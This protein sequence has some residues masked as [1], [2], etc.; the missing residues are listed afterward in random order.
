MIDASTK[1]SN[2]WERAEKEG[3]RGGL[4]EKECR[5]KSKRGIR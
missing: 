2:H 3:K 4:G 5:V 1:K